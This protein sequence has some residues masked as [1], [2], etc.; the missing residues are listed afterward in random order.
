V[1]RNHAGACL[2]GG[3]AHS[4][5][6]SVSLFM[7]STTKGKLLLYMFYVASE[8]VESQRKGVVNIFFPSTSAVHSV[9]KSL[10]GPEDRKLAERLNNAFPIRLV[11]THF[12]IPDTILFRVFRAMILLTLQENHEKFRTK[13]H[14]GTSKAC[15]VQC[16]FFAI[17]VDSFLTH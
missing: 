10:P 12:C 8:S 14:I 2:S 9:F 16:F 11:A 3:N 17:Q 7:S 4:F 13:T 1:E 5:F 6:F 15:T